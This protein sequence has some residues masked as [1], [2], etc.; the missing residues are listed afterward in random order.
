MKRFLRWLLYAFSGVLALILVLALTVSGMYLWSEH[1]VQVDI[2]RGYRLE[3][4]RQLRGLLGPFA[5]YAELLDAKASNPGNGGWFG[6]EG[7]LLVA[8]YRVPL[9]E[10]TAFE[11]ASLLGGWAPLSRQEQVADLTGFPADVKSENDS[12]FACRAGVYTGTGMDIEKSFIYSPCTPPPSR[13]SR[14]DA[15]V[16]ERA[17]GIVTAIVKTYY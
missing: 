15:L 12:L 10:R 8:H 14:Y 16:Y 17:T 13:T 2:A 9:A 7:L 4:E 3:D 6:R 5:A 1:Q 11:A